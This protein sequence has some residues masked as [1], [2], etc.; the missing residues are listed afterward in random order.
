MR[1]IRKIKVDRKSNIPLYLQIKNQIKEMILSNVLSEGMRLPPTRKLAE[2]LKVNRSTVVSAYD[3]LL[4]EGLVETHVG[5]GTIVK[6]KDFS[7]GRD[8]IFYPFD[9]TEYLAFSPESVHDSLI[10]DIISY[11]SQEGVISLGAGVP[12]PEIFPVEE[13]QEI[14]D[15]LLRKEG[16]LIF[17]HFPTEG[18]YPLRKMLADWMIEEGK[19]INADEVLIVAGS[20]Q[21]LY[22]LAKIFL[23]PGDSVVVESPTY[24]GAL[25]V[26]RAFKARIIDIPV[27]DKGIRVDILENFLSRQIPKLIYI[28][29][30]FQN[31]S[32]A[33]LSLERRKKLL[34]LAYK[35][36]IPIIED[37]PYSKL[38]YKEPPPFSLKSLD[39]HNYVIYLST[40]S[41]I[42]FPGFRIG[43]LIAPKAVI[44]RLTRIKQF[45]DLHCNT[46]GQRAIYEFCKQGLLEKHLKKARKVYSRK[47][48]I[49]ISALKKYCSPYISWNTPQGGFYLWCRLNKDLKSSELLKEAFRKKIVFII[50]EAFC[51]EGKGEN[52][53]RLNFT[54]HKEELIQEGIKRLGKALSGLIKKS[55]VEIETEKPVNKPI[56]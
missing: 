23:N 1:V 43:W 37:D 10:R 45:L 7:P 34:E 46:L 15:Y 39:R 14:I 13:F 11:C 48:D 27:D 30:S 36:Q 54:F 3:E 22:L 56:V 50:G 26:F 17:Q 32:G 35:F 53:L 4:A 12:A 6:R 49:M 2:F 40:F 38:Y 55:Q 5:R 25:Q 44:E 41:K 42:L 9:W 28:L 24:L 51:I 52:W 33:V 29:P 8:F 19:T 31:P 20:Q 21:G 16:K 47:R 18:Y